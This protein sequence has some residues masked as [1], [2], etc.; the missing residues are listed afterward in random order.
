MEG[1]LSVPGQVLFQLHLG[2]YAQPFQIALRIIL[3]NSKTKTTR[4]NIDLRDLIYEMIQQKS[5]LHVMSPCAKA[6]DYAKLL[7]K[8]IELKP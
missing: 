5:D 4:L 2:V 6:V 1:N 7:T 3:E 8:S